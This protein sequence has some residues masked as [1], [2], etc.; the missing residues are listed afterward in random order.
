MNGVLIDGVTYDDL[1]ELHGIDVVQGKPF[2]SKPRTRPVTRIVVHESVTVDADVATD[3]DSTE[4][5]LRKNGYGVHVMCDAGDGQLVQHN[6]LSTDTVIHAR[7]FNVNSIGVEVVTPYYGS[8][9]KPGMPWTKV[10][11]APWAH[12]KRYVVPTLAQL[13]TLVRFIQAVTEV[14]AGDV[15]IPRLWPGVTT[16]SECTADNLLL[17]KRTMA[18]GKLKGL[19]KHD[20]QTEPGIWAHAYTEHADGCFP[21]LF[22][23]LVIEYGCAHGEAYELA[24]E[25]ASGARDSVALPVL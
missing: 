3:R 13:S 7:G 22:C 2:K 9:L 23:W 10:L 18:M 16:H 5:I 11:D 21:V 17:T 8:L 24:I 25:L 14:Q 6:D 15:Y 4:R 20:I 1:F 12:K 19:S